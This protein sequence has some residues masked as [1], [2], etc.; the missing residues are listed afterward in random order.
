MQL[1]A[2]KVIASLPGLIFVLFRKCFRETLIFWCFSYGMIGLPDI[3]CSEGMLFPSE[4][5]V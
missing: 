3:I 1:V 5:N 4:S 2:N